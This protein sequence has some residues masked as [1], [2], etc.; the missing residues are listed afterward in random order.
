MEQSESQCTGSYIPAS[1]K[2]DR[3]ERFNSAS[4]K[5]LITEALSTE[6]SGNDGR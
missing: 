5:G 4:W 1:A 6:Y 2:S 3:A